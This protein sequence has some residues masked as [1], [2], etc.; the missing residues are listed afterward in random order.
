[1]IDKNLVVTSSNIYQIG[2]NDVRVSSSPEYN[3]SEI[4]KAEHALDIA[5]SLGLDLVVINPNAKPMI[6]KIMDYKKFVY[7]QK[8]Q[9]KEQ[10]KK[11]RANV[12]KIKEVKF[13]LNIGE[14]DFNYKINH[15]KEFISDNCKVKVQIFLRGRE[16]EMK[17]LVKE[18]VD[19]IINSCLTFASLSEKINYAGNTVNFAFIKLK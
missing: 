17:G 19:K 12:Q 7:N 8:K 14:N 4:I 9:E 1:M 6:V 11:N 15:I 10:A 3:K 5:N 18:L 2:K 16:M 13:H